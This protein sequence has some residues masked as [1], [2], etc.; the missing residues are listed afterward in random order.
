MTPSWCPKCDREASA[1]TLKSGNVCCE[2]CNTVYT[3]RQ[4]PKVASPRIEPAKPKTRRMPRPEVPADERRP[5]TR[6]I[7]IAERMARRPKTNLTAVIVISVCTVLMGGLGVVVL[8]VS[9]KNREAAEAARAN[10]NREPESEPPAETPVEGP[11]PADGSN[12]PEKAKEMPEFD[13]LKAT[14][15]ELVQAGEYN[16]ARNL[17]DTFMRRN[18][19][20][21][22]D[23]DKEF[24]R[25][26]R[27]TAEAA[28]A[29]IDARIR[30]D[31]EARAEALRVAD[32]RSAQAIA[33]QWT[34]FEA[35]F[36]E[37]GGGLEAIQLVQRHASSL[38]EENRVKAVEKVFPI[39]NE[40]ALGY[41]TEAEGRRPRGES[42]PDKVVL[43]GGL[44][45]AGRIVEDTG[46]R[47][48]IQLAKGGIASYGRDQLASVTYGD[49]DKREA[50]L[51]EARRQMHHALIVAYTERLRDRIRAAIQRDYASAP[52]PSVEFGWACLDCAMSG[53]LGCA[54][55][56][57]G[58]FLESPCDYCVRSD[59]SSAVSCFTCKGGG[60]ARHPSLGVVTL[61]P[62]VY[63][64]AECRN[65]QGRGYTKYRRLNEAEGREEKCTV[66]NGEGRRKSS[67]APVEMKMFACDEKG[68]SMH[69]PSLRRRCRVLYNKLKSDFTSWSRTWDGKKLAYDGRYWDVRSEEDFRS[70][71]EEMFKRIEEYALCKD[72][73]VPCPDPIHGRACTMCQGTKVQRAECPGCGGA[74]GGECRA[75]AGQGMTIDAVKL[76]EGHPALTRHEMD[77]FRRLK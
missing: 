45:Q 52:A 43:E 48:R 61:E 46:D 51:A 4:R 6:R 26:I 76:V 8:K 50:D 47:V 32:E 35:Q 56:E 74:G 37:S 5:T 27:A 17:W 1:V 63:E 22:G 31:E 14:A 28:I 62:V 33:D 13:E 18:E 77:L 66:C 44:V 73:F 38:V 19:W 15:D 34:A 65:C 10:A 49:M 60:I 57:G 2:V 75:C 20:R 30:R 36:A 67:S 7:P 41:W 53:F 29:D 71:V 3:P 40:M 11:N 16:R 59:G 68:H 64:G 23:L 42:V 25:T 12:R 69:A 39:L 72:G 9:A 24:V 54:R 58:G 55:C 70:E 21:F